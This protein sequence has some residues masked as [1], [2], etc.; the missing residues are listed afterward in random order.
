MQLNYIPGLLLPV[1]AFFPS[2][3]PAQPN[4][5]S[6]SSE[7]KTS[8]ENKAPEASWRF[9]ALGCEVSLLILLKLFLI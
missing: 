4:S 5:A 3:Q 8:Q 2:T 7:D 1:E 9:T 6:V